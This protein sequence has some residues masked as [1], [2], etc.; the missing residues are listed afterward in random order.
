[1]QRRCHVNRVATEECRELGDEVVNSFS[2]Q[3]SDVPVAPTVSHVLKPVGVLWVRVARIG[4]TWGGLRPLRNAGR[5][6]GGKLGRM[7][8]PAE[9]LIGGG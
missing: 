1:M 6:P 8:E 9:S 7:V 4:V 2:C 3:L 5:I